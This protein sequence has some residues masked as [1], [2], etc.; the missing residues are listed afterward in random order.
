MAMSK[1]RRISL[2]SAAIRKKIDRLSFQERERT[3]AAEFLHSLEKRNIEIRSST[4]AM[5]ERFLDRN[6]EP[7]KYDPVFGAADDFVACCGGDVEHAVEVLKVYE[8]L[9]RK[10]DRIEGKIAA[11]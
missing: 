9:S 2:T 3:N 1:K 4:R 5:V 11:S 6:A 10:G 7:L 8:T